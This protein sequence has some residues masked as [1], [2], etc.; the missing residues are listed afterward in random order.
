M[1][2]RKEGRK[3]HLWCQSYNLLEGTENNL[4]TI[5]AQL[6]RVSKQWLI[7]KDPTRIFIGEHHCYHTS[8]VL[9]ML[10][11]FQLLSGALFYLRRHLGETEF[12]LT[13]LGCPDLPLSSHLGSP[14]PLIHFNHLL[15]CSIKLSFTVWIHW[16]FDVSLWILRDQKE[17]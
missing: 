8:P 3:Q 12:R 15:L 14:V 5:E 9:K 10:H 13:G 6:E 2:L 17:G 7:Q 1:G 11:W 4:I 16:C